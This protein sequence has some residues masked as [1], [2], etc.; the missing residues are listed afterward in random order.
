MP[1][2]AKKS[3]AAIYVKT[4]GLRELVVPPHLAQFEPTIRQMV[5]HYYEKFGDDGYCAIGYSQTI[6][7]PIKEIVQ[8]FH[9]AHKD[10]RRIKK[11]GT[12]PNQFIMIVCD[13]LVTGVSTYVL[14]PEDMKAIRESDTPDRT[15]LE[16][17]NRPHVDYKAESKTYEMVG[18][19]S[20]L[21]HAIAIP[22]TPTLRTVLALNF[23]GPEMQVPMNLNNPYLVERLANSQTTP[24]EPAQSITIRHQQR[25]T[26]KISD[27]WS[28]T[29]PTGASGTSAS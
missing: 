10:I 18:F 5:G 14:T 7:Q 15:F 1:D 9:L 20:S 8:G 23:T 25:P 13:D 11:E 2:D 12:M 22:K 21:P 24:F 6:V 28:R 4:P 29:F 19:D 16:I 17:L 27:P 26:A 3:G